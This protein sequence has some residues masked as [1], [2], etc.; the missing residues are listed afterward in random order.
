MKADGRIGHQFLDALRF[1][2][3]LPLPAAEAGHFDLAGAV[4]AFP[5][6]GAGIGAVSGLGFTL[7]WF[8][9]LPPA[10]CA[11]LA[12]MAGILLT[13]ALHEDGLADMADGFGGGGDLARKL[14]IMRDSRIGTYG[15]LALLLATG[16]KAAALAGAGGPGAAL[17]A[18][19]AAEGASRAFPPLAMRLLAPARM[20]GLGAGAGI[21]GERAVAV[22]AGLGA[23]LGFLMLG[24]ARGTLALLA[25]CA[26]VG[27]VVLI[28]R[29]QIG[30]YT[31]DVL[32]AIQQVGEIAMLLGAVSFGGRE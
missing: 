23:G 7:A 8:L 4:W 18:L 12:M 29:R 32:G 19:V 22:A 13:G 24:P 3:R 28:A 17:A 1:L 2:T 31:G 26:S 9:G 10:A 20:D 11:L 15:V 30:G 27:G 5:L 21:P 6:V 25:A 16:F 14:A